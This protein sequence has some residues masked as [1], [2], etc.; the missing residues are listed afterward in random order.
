MGTLS[1][2]G[3]VISCYLVILTYELKSLRNGVIWAVVLEST[4]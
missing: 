2:F 3:I 4:I 1:P